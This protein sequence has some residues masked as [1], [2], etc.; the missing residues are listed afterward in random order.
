MK[1][2]NQSRDFS[3]TKKRSNIL[4][5][6]AAILLLAGILLP[7]STLYGAAPMGGTLTPGTTDSVAWTGTGTGPAAPNGE[8][9]CRA[10]AAPGTVVCDQ[11]TLTLLGDFVNK[12]ARVQ[13]NWVSPTTDYDMYIHKDSL[14]GPIVA[15]AAAGTTTFEQ[16]DIDPVVNGYGVYVVN[17]V[18]FAA[19]PA[20]QYKGIANVVTVPEK[21]TPPPTSL[22]A[23]MF[24]NYKPPC[25]NPEDYV[26]CGAV[27]MFR[28]YNSAG[29]PSVGV[30]WNTGNVLFQSNL[31][32]LR[33]T[34]DDR[35]SPARDIWASRQSISQQQS[36]DPI[37]F[38]DSMTGRTIPGQLIIAGGTSVTAIT[39]DDAETFTPSAASGITSGVDHQT[40][41]AGPYRRNPV[42]NL[43]QPGLPSG[44][45][46]SYPNA[47][48]YASQD[49]GAATTARSDDG[50]VTFNP[51]VP[52]YDISQCS[53]LHGHVKVAPDG[54]V[55]V[56]N[57]NCSDPDRNPATADGGQGFA[58]SEDNGLTWTVR[59]VPGSGSGDNDPAVG[60]G[61]GGRVYLVYTASNKRIR[62]AVSDDRGKTFQFD[63]DIGDTISGVRS[64]EI[65]PG[66]IGDITASVF[67]AAVGGD[68]NRAAVFF[69]GTG[70]TDPNDP[71]GTDGEPTG[72]GASNGTQDDFKGTWYPYIGTTADGGRSWS[73]VRAGDAVQQGV[74]CTNGTTCPTGTRNLLDFND[75]QVDRQGRPVAGYADGCVTARCLAIAPNSSSRLMND[76]SPSNGRAASVATIIRQVSGPRLFSD[77]DFGGPGAPT[78]PPP[79]EVSANKRGGNNLTW[80]TPDDNG[81]PITGYKVYRGTGK[82]EPTLIGQ[83]AGGTQSFIDRN[84]N[85][86]RFRQKSPV[87][88]QVT[89]TN[90]YG[91]SP[92]TVK[93]Y[94][95]QP[96]VSASE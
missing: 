35:T 55:Y 36:F 33:T 72:A 83:V 68:N 1:K 47:W 12:R 78:L 18:Y 57:K 9:D 2:V 40:I 20:D 11:F 39:D 15:T 16:A 22:I 42:N 44:P 58:V 54:T 7:T 28:G 90:Q 87:Y 89:V 46:T 67:P 6:A 34:F 37:M 64:V 30:N 60:I 92:R 71:T 27:G 81:S 21:F 51:A 56:P 65:A 80:Q 70:S 14:D 88:Y 48:Y 93:A 66:V 77:F 19:T 25:A 52:M 94:A 32:T 74:I 59:T 62:T 53:G 41:G 63:Q 3:E 45:A 96:R 82:S 31:F 91:E 85:R 24:Q 95:G 69:L 29:E 79:V 26:A 84:F 10:P 61:A 43:G 5:M 8:A 13:I 38:T 23:S 76:R 73:V 86:M 4:S 75:L 49:I 17:V 50:G